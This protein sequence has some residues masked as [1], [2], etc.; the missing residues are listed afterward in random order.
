MHLNSE[1]RHLKLVELHEVLSGLIKERKW[2]LVFPGWY[3]MYNVQSATWYNVVELTAAENKS[4][5][6]WTRVKSLKLLQGLGNKLL[7]SCK[8]EIQHVCKGSFHRNSL[9]SCLV[10]LLI[11]NKF[12]F[13]VLKEHWWI[14]LMR[15]RKTT[16]MEIFNS[17]GKRKDDKICIHYP[18][19]IKSGFLC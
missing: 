15:S 11:C 2:G 19:R 7:P 9:S 1:S 16:P 12:L 5:K 10:V 17:W 14:W 13:K 3:L 4:F 8:T 6:Y 18:T